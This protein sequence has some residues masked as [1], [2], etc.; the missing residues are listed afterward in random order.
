M[1]LTAILLNIVLL[2][3]IAWAFA[4]YGIPN[5]N[6]D[7]WIYIIPGTLAP[8]CSLLALFLSSE[9]TNLIALYFKRKTLEEKL[10]IDQLSKK[11]NSNL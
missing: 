6:D 7:V 8:I 9:S 11:D 1:R 2:G 10:K 5:A 4:A 3:V